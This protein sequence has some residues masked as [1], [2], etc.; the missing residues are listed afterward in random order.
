MFKITITL[1]LIYTGLFKKNEPISLHNIL[2]RK[3]NRKLQPSHKCSTHN[4]LLF[5]V[6]QVFNVVTTCI[7]GNI[8]AIRE[9]LPVAYQHITIH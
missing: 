8:N 5:P 7:M 2:I 1:K 4:Q 9:F 3:S 6:L